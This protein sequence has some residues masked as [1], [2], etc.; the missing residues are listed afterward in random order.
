MGCRHL[1]FLDA[2]YI[3][4]CAYLYLQAGHTVEDLAFSAHVTYEKGT[5]ELL[6]FFQTF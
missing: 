6:R 4:L 3:L 5:P 1:I 2:F